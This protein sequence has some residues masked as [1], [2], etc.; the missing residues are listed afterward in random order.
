MERTSTP[1]TVYLVGA[2]PGDPELI[3]VK[4]QRLLERADVV[5][6]DRLVHSDL[7]RV[8][9][10]DADRYYVGK[11]PGEHK[12]MQAEIN[13]LLATKARRGHTVVRLKGGD[14]FVF[15]RGGEEALHL[16]QAGVD[17]EVVPG[18]S[19][20]TGVPAY[21]GIP[22]THRGRS[23]AFTVVTGHTCTMDDTALDW[24]HLTS[25]DTL[26][27]LMGLG[28]LP[29][30][31]EQLIKEGRDADTPVAVIASGATDDQQVVR[32][33][34]DT[35]EGRLGPLEPPAT[36]VIGEVA[37]FGGVIDWV[38]DASGEGDDFPTQAEVEPADSSDEAPAEAVP[39]RR[40]PVLPTPAFSA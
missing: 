29:Q 26:V 28:R 14:P 6:Y 12:V 13:A 3:T 10:A 5:V 21:A 4:G 36:I 30:I 2:G 11:A 16:R 24:D 17:F 35:I 33:T 15:G 38:G 32:G 23:R 20:A 18:I 22:V 19:S 37:R 7:V 1:G 8:A 40:A 39:F 31:A 34:L 27:V 9:D 25:V